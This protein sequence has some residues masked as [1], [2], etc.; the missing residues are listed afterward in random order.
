V[1]AFVRTEH[2]GT[3]LGTGDARSLLAS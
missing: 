1:E 2:S 3:R